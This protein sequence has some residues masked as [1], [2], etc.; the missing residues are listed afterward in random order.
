MNLNFFFLFC[1]LNFFIDS[2]LCV[3]YLFFAPVVFLSTFS[4]SHLLMSQQG[5]GR[6]T[7]DAADRRRGLGLQ[8]EESEASSLPPLLSPLPCMPSFPQAY[9]ARFQPQQSVKRSC[10]PAK[11]PFSGAD[12][13]NQL[14]LSQAEH[15]L[16]QTEALL[17]EWRDRF[18]LAS[19]TQLQDMIGRLDDLVLIPP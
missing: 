1:F 7:R 14:P 5:Q 18:R 15:I 9:Q 19:R 13:P 3:F 16:L 11:E 17:L 4:S 10:R 12:T 8:E 6:G 2:F